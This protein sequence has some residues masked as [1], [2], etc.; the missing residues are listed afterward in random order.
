LITKTDEKAQKNKK[1][2]SVKKIVPI[3]TS[4]TWGR[5][6]KIHKFDNK[7]KTKKIKV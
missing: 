6:I 4:K 1:K 7:E 5:L 2:T 3:E